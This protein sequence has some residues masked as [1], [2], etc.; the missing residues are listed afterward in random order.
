MEK[1]QN[2]GSALIALKHGKRVQRQSWTKDPL[3]VF[4]QVPATIGKETVPK[5]QSLPQSVKDEFDRRFKDKGCQIDAIYY[6]YQMAMVN[7][8]NLITSWHPSIEDCLAEDW[9]IMD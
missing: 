6:D 9:I 7:Q 1:N 5:M 3:F 4:R 8:Y 2:F